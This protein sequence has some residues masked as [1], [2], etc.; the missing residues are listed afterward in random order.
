MPTSI[1]H[2]SEGMPVELNIPDYSAEQYQRAEESQRRVSEAEQDLKVRESLLWGPHDEFYVPPVE[3]MEPISEGLIEVLIHSRMDLLDSIESASYA[4]GNVLP[5]TSV[6]P[7]Y[8]R[9]HQDDRRNETEFLGKCLR[10]AKRMQDG[11]PTPNLDR[12]MRHMYDK[13]LES[14]E[15][16]GNVDMNWRGRIGTFFSGKV[17]MERMQLWYRVEQ[18]QTRLTQRANDVMGYYWAYKRGKAPSAKE[19]GLL[20]KFPEPLY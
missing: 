2:L 4:V 19:Q 20:D 8:G 18:N 17:H 5:R 16:I 14:A 7:K 12:Y 9:P 13:A 3:D 11:T 1:T 10:E 6:D 15:K